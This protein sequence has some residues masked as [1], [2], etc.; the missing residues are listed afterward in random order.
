MSSAEG[1]SF[2]SLFP[3]CV[4]FVYFSCL[5]TLAGTASM[6][7]NR[8]DESGNPC[9]DPELE[10]TASFSPLGP[11]YDRVVCTTHIS[12]S[13]GF[14][15]PRAVSTHPMEKARSSGEFIKHLVLTIKFIVNQL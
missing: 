2:I 1:E 7:L 10:E 6:T 8:N 13:G 14:L 11:P 15:W 5:V 4:P 9:L 12:L 3:I